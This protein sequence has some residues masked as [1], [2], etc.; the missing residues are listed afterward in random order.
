LNE[1]TAA[2]ARGLQELLAR[3]GPALPVFAGMRNWHPFLHETLEE[4]A[5][6]G[7]RRVLGIILSPLRTEASWDR[8]MKDVAEARAKVP[9]APDVTFAPAWSARPRYAAAVADRA[10]AA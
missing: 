9:G 10:R 3:S 4:M 2:Q 6:K 7:V 8:Y 5:G 1:L